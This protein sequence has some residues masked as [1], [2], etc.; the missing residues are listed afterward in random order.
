MSYN[1]VIEQLYK[2]YLAGKINHQD[3]ERKLEVLHQVEQT[4]Q[5]VFKSI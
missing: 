4:M 2:N 3:Y 5:S 1:E